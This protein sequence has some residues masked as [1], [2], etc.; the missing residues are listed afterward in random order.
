MYSV[1][2]SIPYELRETAIGGVAGSPT[3]CRLSKQIFG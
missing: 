1:G 3:G 2:R